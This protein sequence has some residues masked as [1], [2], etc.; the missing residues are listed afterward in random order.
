[1]KPHSAIQAFIKQKHLRLNYLGDWNLLLQKAIVFI[2]INYGLA[3]KK[4]LMPV[5][6][7]YHMLLTVHTETSFIPWFGPGLALVYF[8]D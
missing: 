4:H 5:N 3:S 8:L 2:K 6:Y 7:N 1:M